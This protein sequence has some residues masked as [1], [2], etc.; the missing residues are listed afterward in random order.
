MSPGKDV[1]TLQ[2]CKGRNQRLHC[3]D[4]HFYR[5]PLP[6]FSLLYAAQVSVLK[7]IWFSCKASATTH[8]ITKNRHVFIFFMVFLLYFSFL[9]PSLISSVLTLT[10]SDARNVS[11]FLFSVG[12]FLSFVAHFQYHQHYLELQSCL[13]SKCVQHERLNYNLAPY[14]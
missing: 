2:M 13:T 11:C 1:S 9:C 8:H 6:F 7:E 3:V 5:K 4:M 14:R 10:L 12:S